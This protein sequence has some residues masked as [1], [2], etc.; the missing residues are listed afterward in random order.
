[1]NKQVKFSNE[2]RNE[3]IEGA[4]ILANAVKATLGAKGRNVVIRRSSDIHVTKDGVTV[5][6]EIFLKD[7]LQDIGAQIIKQAARKT[8]IAAGDGTTTS[9]V[10]AQSLINQGKKLLEQGHSPMDIKKGMEQA[11]QAIT[12]SL[13]EMATPIKDKIKDIATI[14]ANNDT[15]L[16]SIIAAAFEAVGEDGV[17]TMEKSKTEKT[18]FESIDGMQ[19]TGGY[20]SPYF[21]NNPRKMNTELENPLVLVHEAE[22]GDIKDLLPVLEG[23]IKANRSIIIVCEEMYGSALDSILSNVHQKRIKAVVAGSPSYGE[24]RKLSLEDIAIVTGA[25][26][27]SK[28]SGIR[29]NEIT[30]DMLGECDKVIVNGTHTTYIGG[31]G[32]PEAIEARKQEIKQ[33]IE[34]LDQDHKKEQYKHRLAKLQ[35]GVAVVYVGA[36]TDVEL[37]EKIDRVEDAIH[38]TRAAIEEGIVVGGGVALIRAVENTPLLEDEQS[39]PAKGWHALMNACYAPL[40]AIVENA[41]KNVDDVFESIHYNEEHYGFN[42]KTEEHCNLMEAGVIDPVKVTRCAIENAVS[43]ASMILTTEVSIVDI[44]D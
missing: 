25:K 34:A 12:N 8:A 7:K 17:V 15:E 44:D 38:A 4:N 23:V 41:G 32:N 27:I 21:I 20:V 43:V 10:L 1:M 42:A 30:F 29:T 26:F 18:Y 37:R 40:T 19:Y 33:A 2:A 9:T 11:L 39:S 24:D 16:G 35:S 31:K 6:E 3:I 13:K 22:I 5:A 36:L 14:S 28:E